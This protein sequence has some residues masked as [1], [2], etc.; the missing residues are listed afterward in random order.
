VLC[1][2]CCFCIPYVSLLSISSHNLFLFIVNYFKY[3]FGITHATALQ[4]EKDTKWEAKDYE[5]ELAKLENE[6]EERLDA[7]ISDMKSKVEKTGA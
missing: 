5:G 4:A 6:A 7:K 3:R 2:H 1:T